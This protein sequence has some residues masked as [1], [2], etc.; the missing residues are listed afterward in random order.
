MSKIALKNGGFTVCSIMRLHFLLRDLAGEWLTQQFTH[1]LHG[2]VGFT[3]ILENNYLIDA[4]IKVHGTTVNRHELLLRLDS[5]LRPG[6]WLLLLLRI[7]RK[8]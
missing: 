5:C 6:S 1:L 4:I 7:L 8:K 2:Y 3:W